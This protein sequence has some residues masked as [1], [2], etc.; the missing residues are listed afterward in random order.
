MK[1]VNTNRLILLVVLFLVG[2]CAYI[3]GTDLTFN[4]VK[5]DGP[6]IDTFTLSHGPPPTEPPINIHLTWNDNST[7]TTMVITW[8]TLTDAGTV[9]KYGLTES[10]GSEQS[11]SSVWSSACSQ[12]IH[13]VKLTGLTPGTTYRYSCGSSAGGFSS[14]STFTTGLAAG[15]SEK[16][17]F[18]IGGDS[19][20][21]DNTTPNP[22]Y[23]A[24]RIDVMNAIL[25]Y[26][27]QFAIHLGDIPNR[28]Q[29]QEQWDEIFDNLEPQFTTMPYMPCWGSHGDPHQ[30][31]NCY[32]QFDLPLN[33]T[34]IGNEQYYSFDYGNVHFTVLYALVTDSRIL[35]GSDQYNWLESDLQQA[36]NN[37]NID[38]KFVCVHSPPY[39]TAIRSTGG[40]NPGLRA[41]V[42]PLFDA[43]NVDIVFTAHEHNFEK[44]HLINN[45]TKVQDVPSGSNLVDPSG[46]IYYVSGGLGA[47]INPA[48][49]DA[50]F[51]ANY[52]NVLHFLLVDVADMTVNIKA[53]RTNLT[54]LDEL[55]ISKSP[56][57]TPGQ[58]TNPS[59]LSAEPKP[60]LVLAKNPSP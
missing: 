30:A 17:V 26:N 19:R 9:V 25:S 44:T 4:A 13:T 24:R 2:L 21:P 8:A 53:I 15:S 52:A 28:G 37:P 22:T 11:G 45:D 33:G 31:D 39:S 18:S 41:D 40:S 34:G 23:A 49:G 10:Y 54:L 32:D 35:P 59:P 3:V 57:S 7:D 50:W 1:T 42:C 5:P 58:A 48:D 20:N 38:W 55:T 36:D 6:A 46:R 56:P 14:N 60:C 16:F 51:S 12:Y 27:P 47:G 29:Y 43:Y